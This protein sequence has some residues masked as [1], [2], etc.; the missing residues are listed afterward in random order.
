MVSMDKAVKL[1][2]HWDI[3][4]AV[5]TKPRSPVF[6]DEEGHFFNPSLVPLLAHPR[7]S[8]PSADIK[9]EL[10]I[11]QLSR[12]LFDTENM[13]TKIVNPALLAIQRLPLPRP[14]KTDAYKIYTDEGYHALMSAEARQKI[15]CETGVA[16]IELPV[17]R[18]QMA[19]LDQIA[20]LPASIQ[21]AGLFCAAAVNETL[22]SANLAQANDRRLIP[23]VRKLIADHADDEAVH[24][25]FFSSVFETLW[26]QWPRE[27]Q[28]LL[29]PIIINAM[30][31][32]LA[33]D[34]LS[35]AQDLQRIGVAREQALKISTEAVAN[36]ATSQQPL[37]GTLKM[38]GKAGASELV[39][40][41]RAEGG[42]KSR[43]GV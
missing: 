10:S 42:R 43:V 40:Q 8:N 25:V 39:D 36:S 30:S 35:L 32:F 21:D 20:V 33:A 34:S 18:T 2:S 17:A 13:E 5:R 24:H 29:A 31:A 6:S 15:H 37:D 16:E 28:V 11:L 22:I 3:R 9:R 19:I 14:V 12:Y 1:L 7:F 4:A 38:L 27:E 23:A 41:V 26:R